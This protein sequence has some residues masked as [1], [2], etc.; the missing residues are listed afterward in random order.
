MDIAII[1]AGPRGLSAL[2]SLSRAVTDPVTVHLFGARDDGADVVG[3]GTPYSPDQPLFSRLNGHSSVVDPF[4]A[5]RGDD[6]GSLGLSFDDWARVNGH[7][8]FADD[9]P[10]RKLVGEYFQYA[11]GVIRGGLPEHVELREYERAQAVGGEPGAWTIDHEGGQL[12]VPELLLTVGHATVPPSPLTDEDVNQPDGVVIPMP[13]PLSKLDGISAGD[14]VATRGAG[15]TFVDVVLELT[16]GRGGTFSDD[17]RE[18]T[19]S[20]R[21]PEVIWATNH[22]GVFPDS[23]PPFG[24]VAEL[25][26]AERWEEAKMAVAQSPTLED[27]LEAVRAAAVDALAAQGTSEPDAYDAAIAAPEPRPG[28]ARERLAESVASARGEIPIPARQIVTETWQ[29]LMS[30]MIR[31][32]SNR[33]FAPEDWEA[34][35]AGFGAVGISS[36]GPP[37]VNAQKM[38]TLVDAG[39]IKVELLDKAIDAEDFPFEV[40]AFVDCVLPPAGFWRGAYPELEG[41]EDLLITW[42]DEQVER[43]GVRTD[44]AGSVLDANEAPIPGLAAVGR[45][46]EDWTVEMDNLDVT[47]HPFILGWAD[48]IAR[49]AG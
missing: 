27:M 3:I 44:G 21:E 28:L 32:V 41:I 8:E 34:F 13:Y 4:K 40:D 24:A 29:I 30:T 18:F 46:N 26:S 11:A 14:A 2:Y 16:E 47:A 23:K 33:I 48:R 49:M 38:L 35:M 20:G 25:V 19:P 22:D 9:F 15:L 10:P 37:L 1:G 45:I 12:R 17:A 43:T 6:D 39:L 5:H 36:Y 31:R 42:A 7:E